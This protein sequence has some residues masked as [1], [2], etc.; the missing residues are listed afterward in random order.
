MELEQD[1]IPT[2][3]KLCKEIKTAPSSSVYSEI[4]F[5]EVGN[6]YDE[7]RNWLL[8][9]ISKKLNFPP[10]PKKTRITFVA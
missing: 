1:K 10:P 4:L 7:K 3:C 9:K 6:F 8:L 2:S 5:F